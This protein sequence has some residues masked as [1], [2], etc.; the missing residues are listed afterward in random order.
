MGDWYQVRG[1]PTFFS[2][3]GS[4]CIRARYGVNDDGTVSVYNVLNYPN[5]EFGEI[6]GFAFAPNPEEPGDLEVHFPLCKLFTAI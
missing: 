6:C 2:P 5:G 4:N 3:P 1:I